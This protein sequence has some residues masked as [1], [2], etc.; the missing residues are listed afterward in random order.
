MTGSAD[1]ENEKIKADQRRVMTETRR[2]A[3]A[4]SAILG[5]EGIFSLEPP[6]THAHAHTHTH[7]HTK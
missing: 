7:T 2:Q 5:P 6:N 4:A 3:G 1:W